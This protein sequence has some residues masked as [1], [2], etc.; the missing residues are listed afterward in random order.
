M[1]GDSTGEQGRLGFTALSR[2]ELDQV[3]DINRRYRDKFAMPLIVALALHADRASVVAEMEQ[4]IGNEPD[5]EIA[6]AIEQIGHITKRR[7][8]QK[9]KTV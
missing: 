5:T 3:S 7:L 9:F 4:R 2:A 6:N 1:T 8:A